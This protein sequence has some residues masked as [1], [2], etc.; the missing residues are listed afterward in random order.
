MIERVTSAL[1]HGFGFAVFALST[2][3]AMPS[4]LCRRAGDVFGQFERVTWGSVPIV[5]VAG[6]SVGW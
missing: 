2:L 4:A 6:L 5:A 1:G 3:L